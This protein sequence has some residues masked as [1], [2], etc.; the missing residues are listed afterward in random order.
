LPGLLGVTA[1]ALAIGCQAPSGSGGYRYFEPPDGSDPWSHPIARWQ[2]REGVA[3][4]GPAPASGAEL[5]RERYSDFLAARRRALAAEVAT[6][7]QQESRGRYADDGAADV[8]KS[9][10][11]VLAATSEDCDGLELLAYHALR[12][13]GFPSRELFRAIL[14]HESRDVHHMVTLWFETPDDPWVIDPTAAVT[15]P[16]RRM[17]Q[18]PHWVPVKVFSETAE[19]SVRGERPAPAASPPAALP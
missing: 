3:A 11:E 18:I 6:W 10:A 13:L 9:F 17:S 8:W 7:V 14:R 16:L 19:Y 15:A 2:L 1:L 12:A 5:L 4:P